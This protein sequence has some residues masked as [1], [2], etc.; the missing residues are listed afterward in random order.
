MQAGRLSSIDLNGTELLL[1]AGLRIEG[2]VRLSPLVLPMIYVRLLGAGRHEN[3]CEHLQVLV[4]SCSFLCAVCLT[5]T[6]VVIGL[7]RT[8]TICTNRLRL[9]LVGSSDVRMVVCDVISG[10]CVY[11]MRRQQAGGK[12]ATEC[13]LCMSLLLSVVTGN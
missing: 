7:L 5:S 6:P 13:C 2:V 3:V 9:V 1:V 11:Y 12:V 4:L 10:C 8:F